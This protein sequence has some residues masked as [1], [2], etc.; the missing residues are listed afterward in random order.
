MKPLLL[1]AALALVAFGAQAETYEVKMLNKGEAGAMVFEPA[2]VQAQPGDVIRFVPTDR[3]HN[4]EDIDGMLPEGVE[5][6]RTN[7]NE[8]FELTVDAEGLYGIKCTP[9]YTMGMV[10][11]IQVGEPVNLDDVADLRQK[12]KAKARMADLIAQVQ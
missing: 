12:G 5:G 3:G 6:F 2:F 8:E 1:S 9:H 11:L 4:V 10:A 7:F